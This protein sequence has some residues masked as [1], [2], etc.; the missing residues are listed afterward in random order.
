MKSVCKLITY[1]S[2]SC[3]NAFHIKIPPGWHFFILI[4][5]FPLTASDPTCQEHSRKTGRTKSET[6]KVLSGSTVYQKLG[7]EWCVLLRTEPGPKDE[8]ALNQ[9]FWAFQVFWNTCVSEHV[10]FYMGFQ[11]FVQ[12]AI[13]GTRHWLLSSSTLDT[14]QYPGHKIP[15]LRLTLHMLIPGLPTDTCPPLIQFGG[16]GEE[17]KCLLN[18]FLPSACQHLD[19]GS[20]K[21]M[22]L[23]ST[24]LLLYFSCLQ[25]R[26]WLFMNVSFLK[27][28][29]IWLLFSNMV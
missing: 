22:V 14:Y 15:F 28:M 7:G 11:E 21:Y 6:S 13:P 8:T 18:M 5:F 25:S 16:I 12:S 20:Q 3:L 9:W 19:K 1:V 17:I 4:P 27:C 29:A 2:C 10:V 23:I 26:S 24:C